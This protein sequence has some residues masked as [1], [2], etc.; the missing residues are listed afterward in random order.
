MAVLPNSSF[1][2]PKAIEHSYMPLKAF[3]V[4]QVEGSEARSISSSSNPIF[5]IF[6][7][8]LDPHISIK[9]KLVTVNKCDWLCENPPCSQGSQNA[10][11]FL[12]DAPIYKCFIGSLIW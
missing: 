11:N 2:G 8:A 9:V 3:K 7:W 5:S 1:S 10:C 4:L 12:I 6:Q